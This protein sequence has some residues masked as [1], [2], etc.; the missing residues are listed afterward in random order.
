M[1]QLLDFALTQM[2]TAY[3]LLKT[4][5][6]LV[7]FH[8]RLYR[9]THASP[10]SEPFIAPL[11]DEIA[12]METFLADLLQE[13]QLFYKR[14]TVQA[15]QM[16][17]AIERDLYYIAVVSYEPNS[18]QEHLVVSTLKKKYDYLNDLVKNLVRALY[19]SMG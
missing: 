9:H 8:Q 10:T 15:S 13:A 4:S 1:F 6:S 5:D 18:G 17:A 19:Q 2:H 12:P 3:I 14:V 7:P 11:S 16:S